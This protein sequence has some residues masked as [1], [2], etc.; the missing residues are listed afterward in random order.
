MEQAKT[1]MRRRTRIFVRRQA[2]W[3]KSDDP[4]IHWFDLGDAKLEE[5]E[6]TIRAFLALYG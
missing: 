1:E 4:S 3:F 6:E 5:I 2:N